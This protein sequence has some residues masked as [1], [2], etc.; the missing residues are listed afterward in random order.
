MAWRYSLHD[1]NMFQEA[2]A[3]MHA[4]RPLI[5]NVIR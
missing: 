3:E 2:Q 4:E 1:V 5:I